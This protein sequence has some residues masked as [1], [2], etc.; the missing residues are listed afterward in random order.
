MIQAKRVLRAQ[1]A[2]K[3]DIDAIT[4]RSTSMRPR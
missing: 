4:Q 3:P 1:Q 2:D